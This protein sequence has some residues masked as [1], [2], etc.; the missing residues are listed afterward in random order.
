MHV[1]HGLMCHNVFSYYQ[2]TTMNRLDKTSSKHTRVVNLFRGVYPVMMY[3][4]AINGSSDASG[5]ISQGKRQKA[6]YAPDC[7]LVPPTQNIHQKAVLS[8]E[9]AAICRRKMSPVKVIIIHCISAFN[10]PALQILS[11]EF[12]AVHYI[13]PGGRHRTLGL[14]R[15]Q[16]CFVHGLYMCHLKRV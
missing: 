7:P 2:N 16:F 11:P 10:I 9:P 13:M 15:H 12:P 4:V 6:T 3:L 5:M 1:S 14:W 8:H